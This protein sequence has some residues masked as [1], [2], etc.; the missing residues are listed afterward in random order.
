[1]KKVIKST[2]S[3]QMSNQ[4]RLFLADTVAMVIFSF[5]TGMVIELLIA[6]MTLTQSLTSRIL[7]I[8]VNLFTARPYGLYRDFFFKKKRS[9]NPIIKGA[10]D[11][12]IFIS[13]QI[14]VYIFVLMF[15]GANVGQIIKA[16]SSVIVFFIILGRPYGLFLG[17]CR[18]IFGVELKSD[19]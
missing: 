9:R 2:Y 17:F 8:P 7:A 6:G 14:P 18:T 16:C 19:K 15:A 5:T 10:I 4:A 13:F 12:L 1:M 3:D 11:I